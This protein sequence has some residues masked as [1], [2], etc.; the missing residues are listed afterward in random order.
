MTFI[1][2][3]EENEKGD[4]MKN[5]KSFVVDVIVLFLVS[6]VLLVF[7]GCAQPIEYEEESAPAISEATLASEEEVPEFEELF[8]GTNSSLAEK[9]V[10]KEA[11]SK[12]GVAREEFVATNIEQ[13]TADLFYYVRYVDDNRVM[14]NMEDENRSLLENKALR[15]LWPGG[16]VRVSLLMDDYVV[17]DHDLGEVLCMFPI[18]GQGIHISADNAP[19][20][21][22]RGPTY[23]KYLPV[24]QKAIPRL[25]VVYKAMV[26]MHEKTTDPNCEKDDMTCDEQG[27]WVKQLDF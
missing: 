15:F 3:N 5:K 13:E 24:C 14:L 20:I 1:K 9:A 11:A 17:L 16:V 25:K 4:F 18:F 2:N 12:A 22:T 6:A 19:W 8:T 26:D 10:L 7:C 27:D 23:D 21:G